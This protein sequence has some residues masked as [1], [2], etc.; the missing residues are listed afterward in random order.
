MAPTAT[1]TTSS[2]A[3]TA[4]VMNPQLESTINNQNSRRDAQIEAA[5]QEPPARTGAGRGNPRRTSHRTT[6]L[7]QE[8]PRRGNAGN[9]D[10]FQSFEYFSSSD[11]DDDE[12]PDDPE[13]PDG[14]PGYDGQGGADDPP[15]P[16][17]FKPT[18]GE[19]MFSKEAPTYKG[20]VPFDSF[21]RRFNHLASLCAIRPTMYK[22]TLY[23][24]I[25]GPVGVLMNDMVPTKRKY[26][27]MT[28]IQYAEA[29]KKRL[30]PVTEKRLIYQ[31]FLTRSQQPA[32]SVD[33]YILDKFNLFKRASIQKT[34]DFDDFIDYAI[35][36]FINGYLKQKVREA[37]VMKVP[38][39]FMKF[40]DIVNKN[41]TL[42]QSRLQSGEIDSSEATGCEVRI[43]SYS[44]ADAPSG[45]KGDKGE[46]S[47]SSSRYYPS[48]K[49]KAEPVNVV[50]TVE[51]EET[52]PDEDPDYQHDGINWVGNRNQS[53]NF[54]GGFRTGFQRS[55]G[56]G[57][58]RSIGGGA[59]QRT[60]GGSFQRSTGLSMRG[61]STG[62]VTG[63]RTGSQV[64][65][66][67]D[68]CFHCGLNGHWQGECPRKMHG[69]S[70]SVN[71]VDDGGLA[72]DEEESGEV[73]VVKAGKD[74]RHTSQIA[75]LS[76]R[77]DRL[78]D[79]VTEDNRRRNR[80]P[81]KSDPQK[82]KDSVSFLG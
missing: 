65:K 30:E 41:V 56:G 29:I 9:D 27:K 24:K 73:N 40:R 10:S 79:M 52:D 48:I 60:S 36:G 44:Y 78:F 33:L 34:R 58:Q 76:D 2:A 6:R 32:E 59:I 12:E 7:G 11:D 28:G 22:S 18:D 4:T 57:F 77:V 62:T 61:K 69:F 39:N 26:T 3:S 14:D 47:S 55:S 75:V 81:M 80:F 46:S 63:S 25:G 1:T 71:T 17:D 35:R 42:I 15:P 23:L 37:C 68:Q 54:R 70:K 19:K 8:P 72:D 49:V 64:R 45:S 67:S 74:S 38:R 31:Q 82:E 51:G 66:S 21:L 43:F 53:S 20:Q 16:G 13:D 50:E 5:R